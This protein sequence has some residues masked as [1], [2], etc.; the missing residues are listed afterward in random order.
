MNAILTFGLSIIVPLVLDS[1][2]AEMFGGRLLKLLI[3]T[4]LAH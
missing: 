2:C 1:N 3:D 4:R